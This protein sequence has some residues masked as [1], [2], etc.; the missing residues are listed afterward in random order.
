MTQELI[1][2]AIIQLTG[3]LLACGTAIMV[4]RKRST[5]GAIPLMLLMLVVS[6]WA[7]ITW[8]ELLAQDAL[9]QIWW[10]KSE[11]VC[12]ASA[13]VLYFVFVLEYTQQDRLIIRKN[14]L[15]VWIIPWIT[16]ILTLTNEQHGFIWS[17]YVYSS[18][19]KLVGGQSGPFF[20]FFLLYYYILRI[21][22]TTLLLWSAFRY[23]NQYRIQFRTLLVSA[24]APWVS[25][26][27]YL[28]LGWGNFVASLEAHS[29]G[30]ALS[31]IAFGW[32][33]IRYGLLDIVPLA[34]ESVIDHMDDG[35][36]VIDSNHQ[37]IDAN[38]AAEKIFQC[39]L[40]GNKLE[41]IL[42]KLMDS[43]IE[44]TPDTDME[45]V[46][47]QAKTRYL[48]LKTHPVTDRWGRMRGMIVSLHD[49]T[50]RKQA[51][52]E[53]QS[54][55]DFALLVMNTMGQGLT[56]TD[57]NQLFEYVNPSYAKMLGFSPEELIGKSPA[58]FT[59]EKD[60]LEDARQ[61][62]QRG[63]T[64]TYETR[65][66]RKDGSELTAEITGVPRVRDDRVIGAI[67][68]VSD[69]TERK[70]AEEE[71]QRNRA[72]LN[73]IFENAGV[74]IWV[75][76]RDHR[77]TFVNSRWS[78]M[79][80][81]KPEELI[82]QNGFELLHPYDR[83]VSEGMFE[84]LVAGLINQYEIEKRYRR[85]DGSYFWGS[86]AVT[87]LYDSENQVEAI[88][89]FV[90]DITQRKQAEVALRETERRFRDILEDVHLLTVMLDQNGDITFCNEHFLNITGWSLQEIIGK[91]WFEIFV[92]N[93]P[94][95]K[96]QFARAI[97][98]SAILRHNE[99]L[100]TTHNGEKLLVAWSNIL[101]RNEYGN[102]TGM[103][104][105][106]E[107]VTAR[108]HAEKSERE[109]REFA[110]ALSDTAALMN[111]K[112]NLNDTLVE[113]LHN[114]ERVVPHDAA[115]IA[116]IEKQEVTFVR[117]R[118][119]EKVGTTND[120]IQLMKISTK[121]VPNIRNIIKT[122][123]PNLVPNTQT[124][125]EWIRMEHSMWIRS[126]LSTP[127]I[128][129]GRVIGIINLDSKTPYFFNVTHAERLQAFSAQAAIAFKNAQLY[130]KSQRELNE[131]KRIQANLRRAN[132]RL[133]T[134]L[135]EIEALQN[136]L[137]QQAI[138]DPLTGLFNRRYMEETL[139]REISRAEREQFPISIVMMDIDRFKSI[140]DTYGHA[141][142]DATLRTLAKLLLSET[143][144]ADV[145][146]RYGGEEFCIIMAGAPQSIAYQRAEAWRQKFSETEIEFENIRLT[147]TMSLGVGTF[148]EHG[149][150]GIQVVRA[151]D[152]ALY[153][154]KHGGRNRVE[155]A[156]LATNELESGSKTDE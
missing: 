83:L 13:S 17:N 141:V 95:L 139:Q 86:L 36:I 107:D 100:L 90:A 99:N 18:T 103:A 44:L 80:G 2:Q 101:L 134:Q 4:W 20:G 68:V 8:L 138:R 129:D 47:G 75:A 150:T 50:I 12:M 16:I 112:L 98:R 120:A 32:G 115:N 110:E 55:R 71:L 156:T 62:R 93:Q 70:K 97:Q 144:R 111:T 58:E 61:R 85:K 22:S 151:A 69:M 146:C 145:A 54:E 128:V 48:D 49:F 152:A 119:Y 27:F 7:M 79:M 108:R 148:P 29:I 31:G 19:N 149:Q 38:P 81:Y 73:A 123:K 66:R 59:I 133:Q 105:I 39:E 140:N 117:A 40:L 130:D 136:Q 10:A 94:D 153:R 96:Q 25:N 43:P 57:E 154:A 56:V 104:S 74:G 26:L 1:L 46:I 42:G 102:V 82:G 125:P 135:A 132:R 106:G 3:A 131:R 143:R 15:L 9:W 6:T 21:I 34:R 87:P 137:R 84:N 116:L 41:N 65:L 91:N 122:R 30:Y 114:V 45:I 88:I 52:N 72:H 92:P 24:L 28:N 5:P 51:Q 126:H 63:E 64:N 77:F 89:G 142:G 35:I 53:L 60:V 14:I 67:A 127:I 155:L 33:I 109:Q 147:A 37:I 124:D 118:G 23:P 113:I 76:N 11:I 78:K 121:K